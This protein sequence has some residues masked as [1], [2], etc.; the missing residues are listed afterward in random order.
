M[1]AFLLDVLPWSIMTLAVF[2]AFR[3]RD[4]LEL[5]EVQLRAARNHLR[6]IAGGKVHYPAEAAR[7]GL[8]LSG[9]DEG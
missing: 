9:G 2:S 4:K 1:I 6:T 7:M 3:A 5:A 8:R